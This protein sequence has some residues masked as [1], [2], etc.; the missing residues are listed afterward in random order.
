MPVAGCIRRHDGAVVSS[1]A[2]PSDVRP[3][4]R[5]AECDPE[6]RAPSQLTAEDLLCSLGWSRVT[7][8]TTTSHHRISF[9][10]DAASARVTLLSI[11][12]FDVARLNALGCSS[13][14]IADELAIAAGTARGALQRSLRKLGL[15]SSTQLPLVWRSLTRPDTCVW[16][17]R[18][19]VLSFESDIESLLA[20]DFTAAQRHL[21]LRLLQGVS[22]AEIAKERGTAA[23]TLANQLAALFKR[24]GA[25]SR[26]ELMVSLLVLPAP[27]RA[28]GSAAPSGDC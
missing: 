2:L 4:S 15:T 18:R 10:I 19:K 5:E 21:L 13:K 20:G 11:R 14:Q 22:T 7:H 28:A 24:F 12:E 3:V 6:V 16:D 9:E 23:R 1:A 17:A 26:A 8:T 27:I 25:C